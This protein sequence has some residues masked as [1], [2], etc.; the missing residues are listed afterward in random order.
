MIS[1]NARCSAVPASRASEANTTQG[2]HTFNGTVRIM[3]A[4]LYD[5]Y[6]WV[7]R[8]QPDLPESLR[9]YTHT[10]ADL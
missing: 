4:Q 7:H 2:I 6:V 9:T 8:P 5:H 3:Q 1:K 10:T